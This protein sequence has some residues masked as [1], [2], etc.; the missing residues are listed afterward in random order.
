VSL[1]DLFKKIKEGEVKELNII[2]KADVQ[3]SIEAL[4]D[5]LLKLGTEEVKIKIIH[6]STGAITETDVMLASATGAIVIG[7]NVRA[8]PRVTE[9]AEKEQIDIRYYDVIYNVLQE[10]SWP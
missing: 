5:S 10:I 3:G 7:F 9:L 8:N 4:M 2:L 6:S 1:D